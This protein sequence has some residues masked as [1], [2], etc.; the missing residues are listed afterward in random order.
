MLYLFNDNNFGER[1]SVT[2]CTLIIPFT[3]LAKN[4]G[5]T[6]IHVG[7][8][9]VDAIPGVQH[10]SDCFQRL[11]ND[12]IAVREYARFDLQGRRGKGAAEYF[13]RIDYALRRRR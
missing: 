6:L 4:K 1:P 8:L 10:T 11:E 3:R 13:S 12:Y 5:D 7:S 9:L 2:S